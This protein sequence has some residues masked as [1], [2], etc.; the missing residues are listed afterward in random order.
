MVDSLS[1]CSCTFSLKQVCPY[2][3]SSH[4][5]CFIVSPTLCSSSF[6]ACYC[7]PT[8][9]SWTFPVNSTL[10]QSLTRTPLWNSPIPWRPISP[11]DQFSSLCFP[12]RFML[13]K[14]TVHS[15][16]KDF[17]LVDCL[18]PPT[19]FNP[20]H[21]AAHG[22]FVSESFSFNKPFLLELH[23]REPSPSPSSNLWC[24]S[25]TLHHWANGSK[26]FALSKSHRGSSPHMAR[27]WCLPWSSPGS[28]DHFRC[29]LVSV[30][31]FCCILTIF[32]NCWSTS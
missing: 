23:N 27:C 3:V 18:H 1:L 9:C 20:M 17:P 15:S 7:N 11:H 2:G 31:C 5:L 19:L 24:W 30:F 21:R 14:T 4:K 13:C 26:S 6:P 28:S 22:S 25:E 29:S 12:H 16:H 8:L 10:N 32:V